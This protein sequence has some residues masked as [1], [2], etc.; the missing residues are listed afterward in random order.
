MAIP[1]YAAMANTGQIRQLDIRGTPDDYDGTV[2]IMP[3]F[4][5]N[6]VAPAGSGGYAR[7]RRLVQS[8]VQGT[9]AEAL[10]CSIVR[11]GLA[12][13]FS[14]TRGF[15]LV[16]AL[17]VPLAGGATQLQVTVTMVGTPGTELGGA[18]L[19]N[20]PRRTLRSANGS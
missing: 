12:E 4:T 1:L 13:A 20:D 19:W 11:D 9:S 14:L 15:P 18:E 17:T 8:G 6:P 3:S 10:T 16:G 7:L 5:S 2:P